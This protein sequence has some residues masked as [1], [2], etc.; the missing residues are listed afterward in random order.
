[1]IPCL[2]RPAFY[3]LVCRHAVLT[4]SRTL[5]LSLSRALLPT[6]AALVALRGEPVTM[7]RSFLPNHQLWASSPDS[8]RLR[9]ALESS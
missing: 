9:V 8:S 2:P 6:H 7:R 1:V 5:S 4:I 3:L